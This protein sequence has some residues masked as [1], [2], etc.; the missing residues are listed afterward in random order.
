MT[1]QLKRTLPTPCLLSFE[2]KPDGCGKRVA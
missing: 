1:R 2:L